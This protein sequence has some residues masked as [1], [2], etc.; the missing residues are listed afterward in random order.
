MLEFGGCII[1]AQ[2][3]FIGLSPSKI[4]LK[5]N[6][7]TYFY[8]NWPASLHILPCPSHTRPDTALTLF[9]Y[10]IQAFIIGSDHGQNSTTKAQ[11]HCVTSQFFQGKSQSLLAVETKAFLI[12]WRFFSL[13]AG[14]LRFNSE[15]ISDVDIFFIV[16]HLSCFI[17]W[18]FVERKVNC[19]LEN[20]VSWDLYEQFLAKHNSSASPKN[21]LP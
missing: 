17:N 21:T 10:K 6:F 1:Y 2:N 9:L 8:W 11:A 4:L 14:K 7:I 20:L 3:F 5:F 15:I 18:F 13:E 19:A 16:V 12:S